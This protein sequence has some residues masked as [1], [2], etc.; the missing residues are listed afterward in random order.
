M[1]S[2]ST[3]EYALPIIE[4]SSCL[5]VDIEEYRF[6]SYL[7]FVCLIQIY[8]SGLVY[9]IDTLKIRRLIPRLSSVFSDS[10]VI[11]VFHGCINDTKWLQRDFGIVTVNIFDTQIAAQALKYKKLGITELWDKFCGHVMS[12]QHKKRMQGS[13]WDIRPLE[14]EQI[15]YA[16]LDSYYLVY[17]MGKLIEKMNPEQIMGMRKATCEISIKKFDPNINSEKCMKNLRKHIKIKIQ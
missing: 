3:F 5:G 8:A 6:S 11:K 17:L 15:R 13:R 1:D 14:K 16:A 2:E 4:S 12:I 7:G 10:R 9:L